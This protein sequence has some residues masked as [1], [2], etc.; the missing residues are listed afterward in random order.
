MILQPL[1][2]GLVVDLLAGR[3]I[4]SLAKKLYFMNEY[5]KTD[6]PRVA[7]DPS[8]GFVL[9][10]DRELDQDIVTLS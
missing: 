1:I 9:S 7:A 3:Y 10:S 2:R 5:I 6:R 4:I 8:V